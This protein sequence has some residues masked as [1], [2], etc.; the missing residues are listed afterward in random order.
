MSRPAGISSMIET[1]FAK[2]SPPLYAKMPGA[3]I[4]STSASRKCSLTKRTVGWFRAMT[5]NASSTLPL[6]ADC[7]KDMLGVKR[8]K[9]IG[10]RAYLI[11]INQHHDS[12][13]RRHLLHRIQIPTRVHRN[14][15][16]IPPLTGT[17]PSRPNFALFL[18]RKLLQPI[19]P[20]RPHEIIF[21]ITEIRTGAFALFAHGLLLLVPSGDGV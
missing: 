8:S 10:R 6:I 12:R 16:P 13:V 5:F 15:T 18:V 17:L 1:R 20:P 14:Q 9:N 4:S 2:Q 21:R 11:I 3:A 19:G 7:R